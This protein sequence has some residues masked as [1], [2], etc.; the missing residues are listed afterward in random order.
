MKKYKSTKKK[1]PKTTKRIAW[2]VVIC[3]T[4]LLSSSCIG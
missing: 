4:S 1:L 2:E 3:Y